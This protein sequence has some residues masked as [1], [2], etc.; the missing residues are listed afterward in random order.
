M[1][2]QTDMVLINR[3]SLNQ[4]YLDLKTEQTL[5]NWIPLDTGNLPTEIK[6][7]LFF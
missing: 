1:P 6:I 2:R 7:I 3:S 4:A 5:N